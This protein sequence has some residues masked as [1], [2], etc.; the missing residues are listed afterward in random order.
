MKKIIILCL[1]MV[2]TGCS[3]KMET[4]DMVYES[5]PEET[6][7]TITK[8]VKV[9]TVVGI[10]DGEIIAEDE[11]DKWVVTEAS[12]VSQHPISL[13]ETSVNKLFKA[14]IVG[15]DLENNKA[16]LHFK[17]TTKVE[18]D[19]QNIHP[20]SFTQN[21][22][23]IERLK[24]KEHYDVDLKPSVKIEQFEENIF[25]QN[26][27]ELE[28]LIYDFEQSLQQ[29]KTGEDVE[30]FQSY[31]LNDALVSTLLSLSDEAKKETYD[32][33]QVESVN[34][35]DYIYN[36]TAELSLSTNGKSSIVTAT[37]SVIEVQ[38]ELKI[39]N[40]KYE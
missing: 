35:G 2:L 34:L 31:I 6:K 19:I 4:V 10:E 30:T 32:D 5:K 9:H 24:L 11:V 7:P 22:T 13:I 16:Y 3:A 27:D 28:K 14:V 38:G 15:Y 8:E 40:I 20:D 37:Y 12:N 21:L 39:I 17:N 26:P 29:M 33:I 36:V 1:L 18:G 23:Y 25:K